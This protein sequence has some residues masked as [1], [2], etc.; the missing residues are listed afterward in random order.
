MRLCRALLLL[1]RAFVR[2]RTELVLENL[3]LR[4]Q[5]AAFAPEIQA[6]TASQPGSHLWGDPVANLGQLAL[7]PTHR[8][9][10]HR[11]PLPSHGLEA[12]LALEVSIRQT[13]S[14][15]NRR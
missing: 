9:A 7:R 4:Q 1:I 14:A 8:A 10:R 15:G 12:V 5:L 6:T 11:D 13:R 3:T 2:D